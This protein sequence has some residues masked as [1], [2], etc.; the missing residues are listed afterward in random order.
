MA[1]SPFCIFKRNSTDRETGKPVLRY[2]ARFFDEDGAVIQTKTLKAKSET[3][4]ALE[5][6]GFIERG[7]CSKSA[8]PLVLDFLKDFWRIDSDYAKMKAL[9]GR[10][11][12]Y[13]Y[14]EVSASAIKKHLATPLKGIRLHQLTVT[15]MERIII[16]Y[17]ASGM[18][19]RT[20]NILLQTLR[21]PISDWARKHRVPDPL[22]YLQRITERPKE[23]GT[24]SIEE[25]AKIIALGGASPRVKAA[26]LLAALCGLRMGEARGLEWGDVDKKAGM[27]HIVHNWVHDVEGVK[28]PKCGSSRDV[29]LPAAV[30][31]A[32]ELCHDI[33]P[34][35]ARFVIYNENT[36]SHPMTAR[37]IEKGF[38]AILIGIGIDAKARAARNQCYHGLRHAY[39]SMTRAAGLPD[40]VVMRLAG[41]KSLVMTER[42]S[43]AENVVDF[44][45]ARLAL[46]SAVT[47]AKAAQ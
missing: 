7:L 27:L 26:V 21:V 37:A 4:A 32:L 31:E 1:R 2:C 39:V 14:I 45:A 16:D 13:H 3:K 30:L 28:G 33:A 17:A 12:S 23:R 42:Y 36:I 5:A 47:K 38:Q 29:P 9:R 44:A 25:V 40:F 8:D 35:G 41:H 34:K 46:D 6:Q 10:P 15:R 22:Q 24:L 18:N 11:L 19:P 20:I 43:H